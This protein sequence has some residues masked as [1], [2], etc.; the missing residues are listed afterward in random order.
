MDQQEI[1][2][3][4]LQG[5]RDRRQHE[6]GI[7]NGS[8]NGEYDED[9]DD[10]TSKVRLGRYRGVRCER[11]LRGNS[12]GRDGVDRNLGS[13]K[14][15][16]PSSQDRTDPEVYLDWEKRIELVFDSHKF[17]EEKKV[18]LAVIKFTDYVIIWSD[19]LVTNRRK[20]LEKPVETWRELK[21]ILRRK[22]VPSHY[23][24]D[25]YQKLQNLTRGSRSVED[26]H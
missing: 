16:I 12:R 17:S 4:N 22:F 20:N 24:R 3:R 14:M 6:T 21:A 26:Y 25:L 10:L 9:D 1:I 7:E 18:K 23:Y 11:G 19:Q 5:G 8:E 2:I 15:K 13:I